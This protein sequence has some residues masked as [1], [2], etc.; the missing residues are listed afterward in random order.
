MSDTTF[1]LRM[2]F[3]EKDQIVKA[4]VQAGVNPDIPYALNTF[5]LKT[6]MEALP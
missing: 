2:T 4:A 3:A 1:P 5:I 6:L